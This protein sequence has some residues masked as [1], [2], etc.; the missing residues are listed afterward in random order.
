MTDRYAGW[1]R[2]PIASGDGARLAHDDISGTEW[3]LFGTVFYL[4]ATE[5]PYLDI[6]FGLVLAGDGT[7]ASA[8]RIGAERS[9]GAHRAASMLAP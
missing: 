8:F 3:P 4:R 6:D 1:A 7:S 5:N 2:D 9:L